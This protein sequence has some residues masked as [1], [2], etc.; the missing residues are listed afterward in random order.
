MPTLTNNFNNL[1][2][3]NPGMSDEEAMK[4]AMQLTA[5][6]RAKIRKADKEKRKKPGLLE[7][8][9]MGI[10]GKTSEKNL[11]PTGRK[12]K[13]SKEDENKRSKYRRSK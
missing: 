12:Y 7:R 9:K 3:K 1:K 2:N 11:S 5:E 13:R 4:K 10:T 6:S 8:L